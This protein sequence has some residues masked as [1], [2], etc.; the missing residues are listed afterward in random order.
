MEKDRENRK[1]SPRPM[2]GSTSHFNSNPPKKSI[3]VTEKQALHPH[4]PASIPQ[5]WPLPELRMPSAVFLS[6][7]LFEGLTSKKVRS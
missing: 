3:M 5:L 2:L 1:Q 7:R 4:S 6:T